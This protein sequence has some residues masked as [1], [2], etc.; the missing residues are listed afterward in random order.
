MTADAEAAHVTG[1]PT[2]FT[3]FVGRDRELSALRTR[4]SAVSATS[5]SRLTTLVGLGGSGKTRLAVEVATRLLDEP[6]GRARF[7]DGLWWVD[8]AT[9]TDP[10]RVPQTLAAAAGLESFARQSSVGTLAR[11]LRS[12]RALVVLD[13]CEHL[14]P[15]CEALV[16]ELSS[17][18]PGL[19]V[20]ATSR[21]PLDGG[22]QVVVKSGP[23][24]TEAPRVYVDEARDSLI[25][26]PGASTEYDVG[27]IVSAEQRQAVTI[28][29]T[30]P[31]DPSRAVT[32][33][34]AIG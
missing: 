21:T 3:S 7:P 27:V 6:H 29:I 12:R 18:C 2:Y 28:E 8:L 15:A 10:A 20:L 24:G 9:V 33:T 31:V 23:D 4:L 16:A 17:S 30:D 25:L 32:F 19:T 11:T 26:E 34:G 5:N 22:E 14:L 1:P 13:N